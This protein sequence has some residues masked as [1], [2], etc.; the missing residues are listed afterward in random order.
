MTMRT[1]R[2]AKL[3]SVVALSAA[4]AFAVAAPAQARWHDAHGW[5][6]GGHWRGGWGGGWYS[7]PP[8]VYGGPYGGYG[9]YPPPVDYGPG[10]GFSFNIR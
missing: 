1:G 8:V 3:G 9:Y 4:L 5:H 6:G 7:A 10:I 2:L